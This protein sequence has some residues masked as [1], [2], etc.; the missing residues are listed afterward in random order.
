MSIIQST[1]DIHSP[2][3]RQNV[4]FHRQL[5]AELRQRPSKLPKVAAPKRVPAT[6][7]VAN[8]WYAIGSSVCLILVVLGSKSAH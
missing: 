2:E 3:F 6:N 5:S 4:D 1:L 7:V 8:Y